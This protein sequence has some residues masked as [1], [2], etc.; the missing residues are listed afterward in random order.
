MGVTTGVTTGEAVAMNQTIGNS[1]NDLEG[2]GVVLDGLDVGDGD[3]GGPMYRIENIGGIDYAVLV[4]HTTHVTSVNDSQSC[5]GES[6]DIG[7][8]AAGHAWYH[9]NNEYNISL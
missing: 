5:V 2:H 4:G 3:S 8:T 6:R 1:C 7:R 9:K